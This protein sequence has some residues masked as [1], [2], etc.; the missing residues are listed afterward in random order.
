EESLMRSGLQ[1]AG[2][3]N[4]WKGNPPEI[5]LEDGIL[6][7]QEVSKMDL[8]NTKLVVLSACETGL[9]EI[10]GSEGVY[11]LQRAFKIAGVEYIIMSLW[12]IPDEQT[13]E[14][15]DA[16]YTYWLKGDDIN[17]AFSKAQL[18]MSEKYEPFFWAAFVL[19]K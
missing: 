16:F 19:V 18:E 13:V 12:Q 6:T 10:K 4:I 7:S 15:M 2:A 14:L 3:N 8:S 9:G 17:T 5:G 1:F 11:G